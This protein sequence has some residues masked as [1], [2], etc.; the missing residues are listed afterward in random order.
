MSKTACPAGLRA[1]MNEGHAHQEWCGIVERQSPYAP[2]SMSFWRLGSSPRS[3]I[4]WRIFQSTPS[5]PMTSTRSGIQQLL[6]L[7]DPFV[8]AA[9]DGLV[10]DVVG[11]QQP[12]DAL[13]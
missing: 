6:Y 10:V 1:V 8:D 9:R 13:V 11:A 5:Q 4:G 2:L 12:E 3:N 7:L